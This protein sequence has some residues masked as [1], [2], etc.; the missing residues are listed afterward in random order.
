MATKALGDP[1]DSGTTAGT[2]VTPT[3]PTTTATTTTT[4]ASGS[5]AVGGAS[6]D[7]ATDL[8]NADTA[9]IGTDASALISQVLADY[10]LQSLGTWAWQEITSGATS[11]QVVL[12]MQ[13]TPQ[14]KQRFPGIAIRLAKGLP[15]I[16]P[17]DYVS[18]EDSVDQLVKQYGIPDGI[19]NSPDAIGEAIGNDV[20]INEAQE[21]I[22]KGYAVVAT[23]APEVRAS[24]ASMFG[25]AG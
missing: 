2:F 8:Q 16:S 13:Q 20:S 3:S 11:A 5:L 24:F 9:S 14:F 15:A 10:G 21:R 12:D 22:Q 1:V 6:G 23:A 4:P 18:Y 25:A 19:Y 7:I 17:A